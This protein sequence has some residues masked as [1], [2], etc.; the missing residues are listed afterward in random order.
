MSRSAL[1]AMLVESGLGPSDVADLTGLLGPVTDLADGIP[2]PSDELAAV[3]AGTHPLPVAEPRR[4]RAGR[5]VAGAAVLALSGVGATGL[6][7][8]ANTL[9]T[10]FQHQVSVF[11]RHNLPFQF[12][13]PPV[14]VTPEPL[15]TPPAEPA[16]HPAAVVRQTE[17]PTRAVTHGRDRSTS[18]PVERSRRGS[19]D[20]DDSGRDSEEHSG[21]SGTS[22]SDDAAGEAAGSTSSPGSTAPEPGD[23]ASAAAPFTG[24]DD[25]PG[26]DG[27]AATTPAPEA[28]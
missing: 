2:R 6:A 10:P 18:A 16:D 24:D 17:Q 22:G 1:E 8:A 28:P 23:D 5:A 3:L 14:H 12:P 21:A 9:P 7:A 27:A 11:S 26:S 20:A 15:G 25:V 4:R 19:S 13:E